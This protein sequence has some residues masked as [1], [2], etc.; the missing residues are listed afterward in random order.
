MGARVWQTVGFG[1]IA[2]QQHCT[3]PQLM[4]L[5]ESFVS[6]L[7][8]STIGG[9]VV[10]MFLRPLSRVRFS[11]VVLL[12]NGRRRVAV[13]DDEEKGNDPGPVMPGP[14]MPCMGGVPSGLPGLPGMPLMQQPGMPGVPVF[15]GTTSSNVISNGDGQHS[16][17]EAALNAA[18][19]SEREHAPLKRCSSST[20]L[21]PSVSRAASGKYKFLTFRMV[22]QGRVQLRDVRVQMQAQYWISGSTAFGDRDSH[23]GRVVNLKLEQNYFTTLEQLQVWHK[24]DESS[25]LFRMRHRLH[26]HLDGIEVTVTAVDMASLQQVLFYKRCVCTRCGWATRACV[27]A[28]TRGDEW[29][30]HVHMLAIRSRVRSPTRLSPCTHRYERDAFVHDSVFVNTLSE[31][32]SMKRAGGSLLQADHSK[33]DSYI[34]ENPDSYSGKTTKRNSIS[35]ISEAMASAAIGAA[36]E[37]SHGAQRVLSRKKRTSS[38]DFGDP[39]SRHGSEDFSRAPAVSGLEA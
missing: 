4:V 24:L 39:T 36:R 12:N 30:Y 20:R 13:D 16:N 25:P 8:V 14:L 1:N 2:P 18:Q 32:S 26:Q 6:L 22:R 17:I 19:R 38:E 11:K 21:E 3:G 15:K 35:A 27:L 7:V 34:A 31:S 37:A 10:K 9:Y 33:L 23:K 28:C 29:R 5:L